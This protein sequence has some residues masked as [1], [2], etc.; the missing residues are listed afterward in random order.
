[1]RSMLVL[2]VLLLL[3]PAV[4][5]CNGGLCNAPNA[6]PAVLAA[7]LPCAVAASPCAQAAAPCAPFALTQS[8][9]ATTALAAPAVYQ[10]GSPLG[11]TYRMDGTS[12]ARAAFSIPP[13]VFACLTTGAAK[14]LLVLG[15]TARCAVNALFPVPQPTAT[16]V[17]L[18][19]VQPALQASPCA[20]APR[21]ASPCGR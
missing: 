16:F 8:P 12:Y 13:E 2:A 1:M 7:P 3:A 6:A 20:P 17:N 14:G 5:G 9:C 4:A 15:D 19:P 18:V 11:L 21:Q 10:V